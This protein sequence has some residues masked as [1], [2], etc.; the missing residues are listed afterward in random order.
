MDARIYGF[1]GASLKCLSGGLTIRRA[2]SAVFQTF[3][4]SAQHFPG[5]FLVDVRNVVTR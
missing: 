2:A 1:W 4:S 3:E 5:A